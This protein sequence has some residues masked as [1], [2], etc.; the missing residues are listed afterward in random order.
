[1]LALAAPEI[2]VRRFVAKNVCHAVVYD[3]D[4]HARIE[5]VK[6]ASLSLSLIWK[7]MDVYLRERP[8]GKIFHDP[9][10]ACCAIDESIGDWAEVEIFRER[11]EW[12]ARVAN[13]TRTFIITGYD[14][15]R[16]VQTLTAH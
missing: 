6:D 1:L 3:R 12:G 15:E 7:G 16:F 2:G 10:A 13:G 5:A 8:E 4:M 9:L 11:G 14:H